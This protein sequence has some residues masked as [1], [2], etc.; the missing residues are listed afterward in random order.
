MTSSWG[1]MTINDYLQTS[2]V[3][4]TYQ[5]ECTD[6]WLKKTTTDHLFGVHKNSR[7]QTY[8]SINPLSYFSLSNQYFYYGSWLLHCHNP[9]YKT[10]GYT[11][12]FISTMLTHCSAFN[13]YLNI[14][15]K[16]RKKKKML[17]NST[18]T[19]VPDLNTSPRGDNYHPHSA[20][21]LF[22]CR[23]H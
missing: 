17:W 22:M 16:W 1:S 4:S 23:G 10:S 20:T 11:M 2:P 8:K 14:S 7:K 15:H 19:V 5:P 6:F 12:F 9:A 18:R 3:V 13:R 21:N